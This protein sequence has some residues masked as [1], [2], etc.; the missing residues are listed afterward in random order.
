MLARIYSPFIIGGAMVGGSWYIWYHLVWAHNSTKS[1]FVDNVFGN[2][3]FGTVANTFIFGPKNYHYGFFGGALVG[4]MIYT[5]KF[6]NFNT[7]KHTTGFYI[8][9]GKVSEEEL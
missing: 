9:I 6:S 1:A 7:S 3:I 5:L 2:A 8:P 4:F